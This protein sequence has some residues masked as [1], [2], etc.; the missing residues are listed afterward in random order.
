MQP[1]RNK[2]YIPIDEVYLPPVR[3][4]S[5]YFGVH[6][7]PGTEPRREVAA[8][9]IQKGRL[10]TVVE[11]PGHIEADDGIEARALGIP[12]A[13]GVPAEPNGERHQS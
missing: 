3:V 7:P 10:P 6:R 8:P 5:V 4:R 1:N 11:L 13:A 2:T 9:H 12:Q